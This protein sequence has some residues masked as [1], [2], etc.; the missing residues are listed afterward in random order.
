MF[1][2]IAKKLK[3]YFKQIFKQ[4]SKNVQHIS[5]IFQKSVAEDFT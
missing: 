3:K 2:N 1:K 4:I 5:K